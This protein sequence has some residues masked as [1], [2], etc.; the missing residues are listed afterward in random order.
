MC[1]IGAALLL[2]AILSALGA[3]HAGE[4]A[5]ATAQIQTAEDPMLILVNRDNPLPEGCKITP[6]M[7]GDE[8][9]DFRIYRDLMEMFDAAV[10]EDVW[11][12][13]VSGYRSAWQQEIIFDREVQKN[14]D[15]GMSAEEAEKD[16]LRT[17][18]PPGYS[19]HQTGLAVDLNDVSDSFEESKAYQ[20][21]SEHAP[22]YGFVQRYRPE[23]AKLTGIDRESWH[24][25]Y[26]GKAH[27][28][29]MER[30]GLCL[31]EYVE[32]LKNP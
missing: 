26:V 25:R 30:R 19:E 31:E 4:A 22:D 17:V 8:V 27:A 5:E 32:S 29:E 14:L 24:F 9:V 3:V 7:V 23:K 13:V 20:W 2:C 15:A 28:K 11:F 10:R 16:A 12:W 1:I 6:R 18:Q 21:L